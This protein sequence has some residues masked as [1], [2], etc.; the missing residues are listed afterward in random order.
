M[1]KK[2]VNKPNYIFETSWEVCNMIGGIYTVLSTK[3]PIVHKHYGDNYITI[4]PDVW[5]ET[6]KN[7]DFIEDRDL[8]AGWREA[9]ADEGLHFRVGRWNVESKPI[10]IL[11]DF[12]T[13]FPE[14]DKIFYNLWEKYKVD[15]ISGQWDYIEPAMFGYA[16]GKVIESFYHFYLSFSDKVV[17]H[18]HEWMTGT[19]VL[20]LNE[21]L[22]HVA[23]AFTTHATTVGRS[24]AGNGLPLYSKLDQYNG[25][26]MARQFG[27]LS[28]YSLERRTA[29]NADVF[30]AVSSA[31]SKEAGVLLKKA[32]DEV[33]PNGFSSSL[34]LDQQ[35]HQEKRQVARKRILEVTKALF[36]QNISENAFL[37]IT[38]GRYEFRNKGINLYIEALGKVAR[39]HPDKE[40]VAFVKIPANHTGPRP[41]LAQRMQHHDLKNPVSGEY[42]THGLYD[43]QNDAILAEIRK[44]ELK[45]LPDDKLKVIFVPAYL[46]GNDGIFNMN[47]YDL[48]AGFD[49]TVFPSYYEPWGYTPLESVAF[50][51][52]TLTTCQAGFG[53]W[54]DEKFKKDHSSVVVA[55]RLDDN[56]RQVIDE[57]ANAL[58]RYY[59]ASDK[60]T[61][62]IRENA[63]Q[64]AKAAEWEHFFDHYRQAY[65]IALE[66]VGKR[67]EAVPLKF[68]KEK[69]PKEKKI[70]LTEAPHKDIPIWKRVVIEPSIPEKLKGLQYLSRNLW[71]SWNFKA[72]ELFESID[73]KKW[74]EVGQ[75]PIELLDSLNIHQWRKL[76]KDE[77]FLNKYRETYDKFKTYMDKAKD[78][79]KDQVAYFSMEYGL[80]QS[81]KIYSGGLGVLA[82][83]YL[84]EAS[85]SNE[86]M[87]A[88]GL[89]YRNG[90]FQQS[91]SLF[92]DQVA[93]YVPQKFSQ[94]PLV[95]VFDNDGNHLKIKIGLPGRTLYA[96]IW[97]CN[98]GRIPL[99]LLDTDFGDNAEADRRITYELYGGDTENRLKQEILLG[100]GGIRMLK[101]MG[102]EPAIY[103]SN[104]GHSAFIGL[105]R[106]RY[107]IQEDKMNFNDALE[108][109][110][111]S[112]LFTTH[113]PVPAGHDYFNEDLLRT[114]FSHYPDRLNIA[115]DDLVNLGKFKKNNSQELFSMSVL[116][117]RLSQEVNGVSRIHGRVSQ[118]MFAPLYEGY[119]PEELHIGYVTNGVHLP[120]WASKPWKLMYKK[121]FGQEYKW[122]QLDFSMWEKIQQVDDGGIWNTRR[123]LKKELIEYVRKR[124]KDEM[125]RRQEN[126]KTTINTI[127]SISEDALTIGFARRFATYKRAKLLFSNP[128]RLEKL[129]SITGKPLQF[130]Y[131]GKAH[132]KDTMGQELIKKIVEISKSKAF[133]GKVIFIE[134]YDMELAH[135]LIPGVDIWL[136]TPTRPL[137]ASGTSGEKAVMN[138]VVNFS[139]LDGW[140]AEGYK[141][142]AGFAVAEARTYANQQFQ[143]ELDAEIIYN[144]FEDEILPLYY[145]R[146]DNGIPVRWVQYIKNTI[147]GIAPH[148]TMKRMLEDYK[149]KFYQ[150]LIDRTCQIGKDN[151]KQAHQYARWKEEMREKWHEIRLEKLMVP[152]ATRGA[153][154][155]ENNFST[156]VTIY[157]NGIDPLH[158][159]VEVLFGKKEKGQ[160]SK[161]LFS[162][163][164]PLVDVKDKLA[165]FSAEI[166]PFQAGAYNYAFRIFPKHD[167]M[168]HRQDFCLVK[169]V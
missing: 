111:S 33:T 99:Y 29:E 19:G 48:L 75:N 8:F 57:I 15:S 123:Q 113:T 74:E 163:E 131:A 114:Y 146:D 98:V 156:E 109:V 40:I 116:A 102:I 100:I 66:K 90:Y 145:D 52:P 60:E 87:V 59:E 39:N 67:A 120:T 10:A 124:L 79:P 130:I 45:N 21:F 18:F 112:T 86:N 25:E 61:D 101:A 142:N 144:V 117:T 152:D 108:I 85:D 84:K 103:H 160:V 44:N 38:S 80:H 12:T 128:E 53:Q 3:A 47:Y 147:S 7:P 41:G 95:K 65:S 88:V 140:W 30:T 82:G 153:L 125:T 4:G 118:E 167:L 42:L 72:T 24:I 28:K 27:I 16:V 70:R 135:K 166:P 162:K 23:T 31:T 96:R 94:L 127:E 46:N 165:R 92:G 78:K 50:R 93:E 115:W 148:F 83:D 69:Y 1:T 106:L 169:W 168:P 35:K 105:E 133:V 136:N 138:G 110:R 56:D 76:E 129:V 11:V 150:K 54:V 119:Y 126:P 104:E 151:Y 20:Y 22:P 143:D 159:G 49:F 81:L 107:F 122:N 51:I 2:V 9:A 37:T 149:Q 161:I 158:L 155:L 137:E 77:K 141:E 139:V 73:P 68:T 121:T 63:C 132:P 26:D 32:V 55:N 134:N 6:R 154:T 34:I 64:I 71:W 62:E 97:R 36:N 5:K 91:I 157:T 89:I 14:K 164:M 43:E 58:V 13:L 17:A